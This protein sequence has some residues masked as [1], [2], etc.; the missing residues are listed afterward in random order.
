[1]KIS[2]T[3]AI[4]YVVNWQPVAW[5][6][7]TR[8]KQLIKALAVTTCTAA[9]LTGLSGCGSSTPSRF[10]LL[11]DIPNYKVRPMPIRRNLVVGLGPI[12]LP[13]YLS[14]PQI[15]TR[16]SKNEILIE[17]FHRWSEPLDD[18]VTRVLSDNLIK[19][20]RTHHVATYPWKRSDSVDLQVKVDIHRFEASCNGKVTL[21]V[22]WQIFD[23]H[24]R[25]LLRAKSRTYV[26]YMGDCKCFTYDII[27]A[28]MS[29]VLGRLSKDIARDVRRV[30]H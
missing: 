3:S 13:K 7:L 22:R 27:V 10:Y 5:K 16:Q 6:C 14:Q 19:L 28:C 21:K 18:N 17:E 12:N 29:D 26:E 9:L 8:V 11:S 20:L 1:M 23:E 30:S 25:K 24:E 2:L 15:V 4:H